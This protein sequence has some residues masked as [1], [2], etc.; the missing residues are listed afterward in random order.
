[1]FHVRADVAGR[2]ADYRSFDALHLPGA[3]QL[4]LPSNAAAT[5]QWITQ[6]LRAHADAFVSQPG[7]PSFHF[8]TGIE[9]LTAANPGA[10]TILLDA[11]EQREIVAAARR[12][13]RVCAL[14]VRGGRV[15]THGR[16]ID[17][18]PLVRYIQDELVPALQ[19]GPYRFRV[20]RKRGGTPIP[21]YLLYGRA[22]FERVDDARR[23][24]CSVLASATT[25]SVRCWVRTRACGVVLGAQTAPVHVASGERFAPLLYVGTDGRLRGQ[26]PNGRVEPMASPGR[27]DDDRWHHVALVGDVRADR[28]ELF[29]DGVL[30]AS[31][32]GIEP[33]ALTH[34]QIGAGYARS[35]PQGVE[36][37]F[38][39][40]GE[41]A[42]VAVE[43]RALDAADVARLCTAP[44]SE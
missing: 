7:M 21:N 14:T 36:E 8:W 23:V 32:S 3:T 22:R 11:D 37:A 9:P 25:R 26:F 35:W 39:F 27:V 34:A 31:T 24:P 15:W 17:D 2:R 12:H 1:V 41:I 4:R 44:P 5:L 38:P 19:L 29:V 30:A 10:W 20:D 16:P 13:E 33:G 18:Q 42:D 28:Q 40:L 43:D 6:N